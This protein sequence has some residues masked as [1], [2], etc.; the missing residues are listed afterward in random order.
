M[1]GCENE[2]LDHARPDG[3]AELKFQFPIDFK[4]QP[5]TYLNASV[6]NLFYWNNVL[7]D[8]LYQYGFD[9]VAGNFQQNNFDR[10]GEQ[11]DAVIANAQDGAGYNNANFATPPDG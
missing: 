1:D 9:E 11:G 4:R 3:G 5:K 2:E 8:L 6:T 7:H 10:G